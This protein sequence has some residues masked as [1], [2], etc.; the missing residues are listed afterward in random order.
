MHFPE[1]L[2]KFPPSWKNP[3][4]PAFGTFPW[5]FKQKVDNNGSSI[6]SDMESITCALA[7]GYRHIDTAFTYGNQQ[8]IGKAVLNAN[9]PREDLY[10]TSKLHIY[11][12]FY[13]DAKQKIKEAI[14]LIWGNSHHSNM[15]YLDCFMIHYPG[16]GRPLSAWQA[17]I[18]AQ[19]NGLIKHAG[20]SNFEIKHLE[21]IKNA[22]GRFPEVN[23][24]EYHP[25]IYKEQSEL[26]KFC[27]EH[28]I[29]VEGYSPLAQGKDL[30]NGVIKNW[31][32]FTKLL[33]R[34][35]Y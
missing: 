4:I 27:H 28:G 33:Q 14:N 26:V 15:N 1:K 23:Q 30:N 13:K 12:N 32:I 18:E 6:I 17:I 16:V 34:E 9:L 22:T 24:I 10:V 25:W 7:H 11:N 2:L 8:L 19:K 31:Q 5:P 3:S 29:A 35:L 21:I 20:V